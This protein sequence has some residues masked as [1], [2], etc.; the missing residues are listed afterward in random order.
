MRCSEARASR[1]SLFVRLND[2]QLP[3][4]EKLPLPA[5]VDVRIRSL[6]PS[7]SPG[8]PVR[9]EPDFPLS[10]EVVQGAARVVASGRL[11]L[12]YA[13][14]L[15]WLDVQVQGGVIYT[16]VVLAIRIVISTK[17]LGDWARCGGLQADACARVLAA[18]VHR[19]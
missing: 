6:L 8:S 18:V 1:E 9:R 5:T 16:V 4:V 7:A 14:E 17:L 11:S 13:R 10:N 3:V 2:I 19:F 15:E 12:D